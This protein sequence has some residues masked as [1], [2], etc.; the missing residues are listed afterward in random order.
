MILTATGSVTRTVDQAKKGGKWVDLGTHEFGM[1]AMVK[2]SDKTG[3]R[4]SSGRRIVYDTVKLVPLFA[5]AS[6]APMPAVV[7]PS[8]DPIP[9]PTTTPTPE[10]QLQA[11]PDPTPAPSPA[12]EPQPQVAPEP[13]QAPTPEST[14]DPKLDPKSAVH[15]RSRAG[16]DA[17]AQVRADSRAYPRAEA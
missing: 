13:T 14:P 3:E 16:A 5:A 12:P 10:P 2:L 8:I 11:T 17:G 1:L 7:E 4:T 9:V 15:A 6:L